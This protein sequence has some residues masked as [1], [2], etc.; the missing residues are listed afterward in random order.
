MRRLTARAAAGGASR[1]RVSSTS[2]RAAARSR[3]PWPS[4]LRARRVPADEVAIVA[5]DISADALD[6]A[7]ENAV[8]HAVGDA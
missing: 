8:G 2:A 1:A 4:A 5:I 6:L 7:R 3:S